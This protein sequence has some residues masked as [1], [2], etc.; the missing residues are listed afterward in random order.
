MN[1]LT[2][3]L[4][5]ARKKWLR[6]LSLFCIFTLGVASIVA[7]R[8]VSAVVGESLERKL[9][10]FGA[11]IMV[12][13]ARETLTISYGGLPLG[14]LLLDEGHL[15]QADTAR[16]I[17]S[18]EFNANIA[19]VAPKLV[20]MARI[21]SPAGAA[22]PVAPLPVAVV[23]VDW[24]EE[25][26]LKG[27][28]AI[29]GA[30]PK[31]PD[32]ALAGHAVAARLGLAPGSVVDVNGHAVTVTGVIGSTGSD[33]DNVLLADIGFVQRAFNLPD[34]ASFV[35]VAAL[36]AG[37]P[38][39]DIVAQLRA[40][41]PG[42]DIKALR[43]VVEQRMYS[44]HFAQQL[45]LV[46]SLVILLTACAM[47]VMSMLSA[48]NERRREIGILRSVG[49]SRFGVFTVFASEALLVGVAAGLAGHLTGHG[50]ALKVLAL[51]H[52]ADVAPPAF[53][54]GALAL[55]TCGIAAVSVLAAAFPAWKAS[56]VEP[57]AALVSL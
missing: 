45:A 25:L 19:A 35:E 4:R 10:S 27:Y 15:P 34:K 54:P 36:C 1:I 51:L 38:I 8:E 13:P 29:D 24:P 49:F 32:G 12:S 26:S 43:H 46:V 57:A 2:I 14:D 16:R 31:S 20:T 53:S 37:C 47:V 40:A 41:L 44:V 30:T 42:Q 3:P 7:L 28:W 21:G 50:L 18:I 9:T 22:T 55:T 11:N 33:D 39:D 52:M 17:R 23:G 6:T 56:R 5:C 48:V